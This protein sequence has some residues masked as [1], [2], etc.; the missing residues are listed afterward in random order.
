MYENNTFDN[1]GSIISVLI[2]IFISVYNAHIYFLKLPWNL[3][4][5]DTD[6]ALIGG[7]LYIVRL[8]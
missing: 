3:E 2:S 7:Y 8:A 6:N 4:V 5:S 1:T